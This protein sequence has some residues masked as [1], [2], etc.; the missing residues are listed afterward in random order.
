MEYLFSLYEQLTAPL[1]IARGHRR[2]LAGGSVPLSAVLS[3]D[4]YQHERLF[5]VLRCAIEDAGAALWLPYGK[6]LDAPPPL[7]PTLLDGPDGPG[8]SWIADSPS[9]RLLDQAV[10]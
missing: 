4:K 3:S 2:L 8:W 7:A 9:H 10:D 5:G 1:P 6:R